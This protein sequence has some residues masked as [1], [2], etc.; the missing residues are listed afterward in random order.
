MLTFP[1]VERSTARLSVSL[2]LQHTHPAIQ[3]V[4]IWHVPHSK[5]STSTHHQPINLPS[6]GWIHCQAR[7]CTRKDMKKYHRFSPHRFHHEF[8][9]F[10]H[11]KVAAADRLMLKDEVPWGGQQAATILEVGHDSSPK[12]QICEVW[13]ELRWYIHCRYI[14]C[15]YIHCRYTCNFLVL[16]IS[17][18]CWKVKILA[19]FGENRL[20][21]IEMPFV[22]SWYIDL[23][24]G[25]SVGN[26]SLHFRTMW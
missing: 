7:W 13:K 21:P 1:N 19:C 14:R 3:N 8:S 24:V 23:P 2:P 18:G 16:Q 25:K 20:H 5:G 4:R 22:D 17:A 6:Q 9:M 10:S 26:R 11:A 15:R 12:K